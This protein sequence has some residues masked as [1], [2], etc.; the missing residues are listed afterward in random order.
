M[1]AANPPAVIPNKSWE[2]FL[3]FRKPFPWGRSTASSQRKM[4]EQLFSRFAE[5][6]GKLTVKSALNPILWLCAIISVPGI[7]FI[8]QNP[9]LPDFIIWI[10]LSPIIVAI[11]GFFFLLFFDRDK[12]QSEDYQLKKWSMELAQ[13]KGDSR[14]IELVDV[15]PIENPDIKALPRYDQENGEE[16]AG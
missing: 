13:Q 9:D 2:I 4:R 3:P 11:L 14:P 12:L 16:V 1:L 10:L 6:G 7:Y 15:L 8:T 5:A